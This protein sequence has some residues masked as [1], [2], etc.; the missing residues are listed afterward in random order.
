[1]Q[2]AKI[3]LEYCALC[4]IAVRH[5]Y[6]PKGGG[7]NFTLHPTQETLDLLQKI[8]GVLK[9]APDQ[10]RLLYDRNK[11]EAFCAY[12]SEA[13][14]ISF[15]LYC[16]DYYFVNYTAMSPEKIGGAFYLCNSSP[17]SQLLHQTAVVSD[18]NYY[19]FASSIS[20]DL[21][22]LSE[23]TEICLL[24]QEK[25]KLFCCDFPEISK[26]FSRGQATVGLYQIQQ[27]SAADHLF[28]YCGKHKHTAL[29]LID[30]WFDAPWK[31]AL[32]SGKNTNPP[33]QP[34]PFE[35]VFDNR[36][37]YWR[38]FL[39]FRYQKFKPEDTYTLATV[40]APANSQAVVF[41]EEKQTAPTAFGTDQVLIF[42][43]QTPLPL[44]K[45]PTYGFKVE[46]SAHGKQKKVIAERL[47]APSAKQIDLEKTKDGEN[48]I[49]TNIIAYL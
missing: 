19:P 15:L 30:L 25:N 10:I 32:L 40:C 29:G 12:L 39:V 22:D 23:K 45:I 5:K 21:S 20:D 4:S 41:E 34:K 26:E 36:H 7:G 9:P 31:T 14:K 27:K 2:S 33:P 48:K 49:Y 18:E 6:Y 42:C 8:N 38:Y 24:N 16:P 37:T 13:Q 47:P 1:M 17:K 3:T 28:I 35:I 46:H 11:H 43:S 44:E